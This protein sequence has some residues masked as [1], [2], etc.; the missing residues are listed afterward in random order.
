MR[1]RNVLVPALFFAVAV[2]FCWAQG[3]TA[4]EARALREAARNHTAY[5]LPPAKLQTAQALFRIRTALH[6]AGE[7]W[8]ILQLLVLLALGVPARMRDVA[9]SVTKNRWVQGIIFVFLFLVAVTVL[10][11][12]LRLYGHHV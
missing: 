9:E 8:G 3:T 4:T 10:N 7:G 6:F 12:P 1:F 11:A 5:T 2:T